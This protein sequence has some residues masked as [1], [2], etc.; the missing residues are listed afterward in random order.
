MKKQSHINHTTEGS[1]H[2][3]AS[4]QMHAMRSHR[5]N[6]GLNPASQVNQARKVLDIFNRRK[7]SDNSY[8]RG[9]HQREKTVHY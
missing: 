1:Q 5:T 7:T 4:S 9:A 2:K 8:L 6:E 3:K